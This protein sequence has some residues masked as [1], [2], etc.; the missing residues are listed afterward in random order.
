MT[1]HVLTD[2]TQKTILGWQVAVYTNV[3][4]KDI[5]AFL[6]RYGVGALTD[7]RPIAEGVENSNYLITTDTGTRYIL[8]IYEKRVNPADIPFFLGVMDHLSRGGV[9]C[10]VPLKSLDGQM[11]HELGKKP[12]AMVSFLQGKSAKTIRNPHV[13]GLGEGMAKMHRAAESFTLS[14]PNTLSL[15]GWR[16][17]FE[18]FS[19]Q[20]DEITPGLSAIIGDELDYLEKHWPAN[21]PAGVIHAD[22]FPDNVFFE[23]D[24]LSGIIDFYFACNDFFAYELAICMNAWCFERKSEFNI[25]K[26]RLMLQAYHAVRKLSDAELNALPL[27]CRGAALRFLL[28]RAHDWLF[29]VEGA[30][31]TP[32]DPMEY[33][34]KL[35]FHQTV[36]RHEEYGL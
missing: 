22:M 7:A 2:R 8:T 26:T 4:N 31:V 27:L 3:S 5:N 24:N 32:K 1:K 33:V 30:L 25:T 28:T 16:P 14:R 23:G 18:K 6:V 21:L 15:A 19:M 20:V 17:L 9:P 36:E 13:S 34:K 11:I 29:R 12:A 10:P 35:Q